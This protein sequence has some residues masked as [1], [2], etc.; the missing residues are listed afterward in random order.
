MTQSEFPAG[1][2]AASDLIPEGV[3]ECRVSNGVTLYRNNEDNKDHGNRN[4]KAPHVGLGFAV[5]HKTSSE[6]EYSA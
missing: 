6:I 1:W 3:G 4:P 5:F 2:T